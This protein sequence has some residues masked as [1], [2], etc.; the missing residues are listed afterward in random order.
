M[1][2]LV[3]HEV[4]MHFFILAVFSAIRQRLRLPLRIQCTRNLPSRLV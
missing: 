1:I 4:L 3:A 2:A